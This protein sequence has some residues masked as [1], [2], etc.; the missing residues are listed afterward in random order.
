MIIS[1]F[2]ESLLPTVSK[3]TV[4][5]D[6]NLCVEEFNQHV[7]P[8]YQQFEKNFKT[9][10]FKNPTL[11]AFEKKLKNSD[12]Q[13]NY[14]GNWLVAIYKEAIKYVPEKI[15]LVQYMMEDN[16][17]TADFVRE[18][19]KVR[20]VNAVQLAEVL[21][22][23]VRYARRLLNY[24]VTI[25]T[26]YIKQEDENKGVLIAEVEWINKHYSPF[27]VGL[28]FLAT[29]KAKATELI[30][31][32]PDILVNKANAQEVMAVASHTTDPFRMGFIP[33]VLNPI[34]H[35]RMRIAEWQA[36]RYHEAKFEQQALA[37]K[38]MYLQKKAEGKD[39]AK[40]E[41][42]IEEYERLL[43]KKTYELHAME[44]KYAQ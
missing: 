11:H 25:E 12:V 26:N 35:I 34:Y 15:K 21:S 4:R 30:D 5:D 22:F 14:S 10:Q 16:S 1:K 37:T 7:D 32:V 6:L 33:L 23:M 39:D 9:Y 8:V 13:I 31:K 27:L 24:A 28:S 41:K 43:A 36:A 44:E 17:K 3:D 29:K 40:L 20:E 18:A 19:M 42:T 2:L 38:L